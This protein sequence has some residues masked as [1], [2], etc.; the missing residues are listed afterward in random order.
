V[1]SGTSPPGAFVLASPVVTGDDTRRAGVTSVGDAPG[2]R[3]PSRLRIDRQSHPAFTAG[4]KAH[5]DTIRGNKI[6]SI[7]N[8]VRCVTM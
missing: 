5:D 8:V 1:T 2:A 3:S 6:A 4:G 7:V